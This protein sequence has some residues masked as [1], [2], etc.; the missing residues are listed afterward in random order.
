MCL[1]LR[2]C[3]MPSA[4]FLH[5]VVAIR[6][7]ISAQREADAMVGDATQK[8]IWYCRAGNGQYPMHCL[9]NN[10]NVSSHLLLIGTFVSLL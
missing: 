4:F 10:K 8:N 7:S 6:V 1:R 5:F 2:L 3:L 9:C